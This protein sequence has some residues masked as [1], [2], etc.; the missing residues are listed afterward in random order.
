VEYPAAAVDQPI[1][2]N[3]LAEE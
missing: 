3:N 1:A 2:K